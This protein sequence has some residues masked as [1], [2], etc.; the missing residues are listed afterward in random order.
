MHRIS[1]QKDEIIKLLREIQNESGRERAGLFMAEGEELVKRAFSFG[2]G[3]NSLIVTERFCSDPLAEE[4]AS[5]AHAAGADAY[6][7]TEGLIAKVLD[8]KPTP[9]CL[10]IVRRSIYRFDELLAAPNPLVQMVESCENADNLGMLLRSTDAAGVTGVVLCGDTTDPF[11]RR[12]VRGSRGAVFTVP[13]C[14]R[15]DVRSTMEEARKSGFQIIA[16][17]ANSNTD[18]SNI[19]FTLPTIIVAGNEHVGISQ[20]VRET[21]DAVVRIPMLGKINSLNIAVAA[22]VVLYEAVRQRSIRKGDR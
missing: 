8:A 19:D 4:L 5:K 21:A 6:V 2:G 9:P 1:G 22:S 12:S 10:A 15:P 17:S 20:A 18:Y 3:V 16:T 7:A 14:I 11:S 13:L